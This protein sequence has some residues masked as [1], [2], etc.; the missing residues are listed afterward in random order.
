MRL[1]IV[2]K[3]LLSIVFAV[4]S[5]FSYGQ[6]HAYHEL[7]AFDYD[8]FQDVWNNEEGAFGWDPSENICECTRQETAWNNMVEGTRNALVLWDWRHIDGSLFIPDYGEVITRVKFNCHGRYGGGPG[9]NFQFDF[10]ILGDELPYTNSNHSFNDNSVCRWRVP[11]AYRDIT[12][13]YNWNDELFYWGVDP[14]EDL[15]ITVSRNNNSRRMFVNSL[16]LKVWT[17]GLNLSG[18]VTPDFDDEDFNMDFN[19][20]FPEIVPGN[21]YDLAV[22]M[23]AYGDDPISGN[24][25]WEFGGDEQLT[26]ISGGGAFN[27]SPGQ[28]RQIVVRYQPN[29][30][31]EALGY[32][33]FGIGR[34]LCVDVSG[35]L[36]QPELD[37]QN[38][39]IVNFGSVPWGAT[40]T[41]SCEMQSTGTLA[42]T[43]NV[44]ETSESGLV[45]IVEG[46]GP[47][48]LE[49]GES[50]EI[51]SQITPVGEVGSPFF[52]SVNLNTNTPDGND[53]FFQCF[54]AASTSTT[55]P[56]L[57]FGDVAIGDYSDLILRITNIVNVPITGPV[58]LLE[59]G[60]GFSL[61]SGGGSVSLAPG[62]NRWVRVRFIP[63]EAIGYSNSLSTGSAGLVQIQGHGYDPLSP[64]ESDG[65]PLFKLSPPVPNPSSGSSVF[66]FE[67]PIG[68]ETRLDVYDARGQLIRTLLDGYQEVGSHSRYWD[69]RDKSGRLVP[70]GVYFA[71]LVSATQTKTVKVIRVSQ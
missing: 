38:S 17:A 19:A 30:V 52:D 61:V 10:D 34:D 48:S 71:K 18:D 20:H 53:L 29:D 12:A 70:A 46:A 1:R 60:G 40:A 2:Q 43:G 41:Q 47:F 21:T 4:L 69:G 6:C 28:S 50:L 39:G 26:I 42:V 5:L 22:V 59:S 23:T 33:E 36:S 8:D 58:Q 45:Q 7:F 27:L 32:L 16:R 56:G 44:P 51:I 13:I 3:L 63:T 35:D 15:E 14:F 11:S 64:V 66:N 57:D 62:E 24:V 68:Q 65:A 54:C 49:P 25:G 31:G 9:G 37:I 67:I 55:P